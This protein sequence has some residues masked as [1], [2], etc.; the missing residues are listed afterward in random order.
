MGDTEK[1]PEEILTIAEASEEVGIGKSTITRLL[2]EGQLQG[3]K[4]GRSWGLTRQEAH[5][6][7]KLLK[8]KPGAVKRIAQRELIQGLAERVDILH[9]MIDETLGVLKAIADSQHAQ[10]QALHELV[11]AEKGTIAIDGDADTAASVV[12]AHE[13]QQGVLA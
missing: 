8:R 10:N 12:E 11:A 4:F 2:G 7:P 3:K 6:A 13:S 9:D 1:D 5:R